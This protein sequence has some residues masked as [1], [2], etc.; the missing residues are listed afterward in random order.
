LHFAVPEI[1]SQCSRFI[2]IT[3]ANRH[4]AILARDVIG[5]SSRVSAAV[6]A[7]GCANFGEHSPC[8]LDDP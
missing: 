3:V 1:I 8:L 2:P 7:R 4:F 5:S 6:F